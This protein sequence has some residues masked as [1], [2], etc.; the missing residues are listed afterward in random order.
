MN[1]N[2]DAYIAKAKTWR[3]EMVALREIALECGLAEEMKWGKPC[4]SFAGGQCGD[5]PG[6]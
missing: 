1:Q 2:I 6:V 5:H 3:E 4:Y